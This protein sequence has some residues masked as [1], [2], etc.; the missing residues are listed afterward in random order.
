M[1]EVRNVAHVEEG[2]SRCGAG[3]LPALM[4]GRESRLAAWQAAPQPAC[5]FCNRGRMFGAVAVL[6]LVF[7]M[8]C[9]VARAADTTAQ[10]PPLPKKNGAVL[11][12]AQKS[13]YYGERSVKVYLFYPGGT[14]EGVKE[15]TGLFLSL[16]NWGGREHSGAPSPAALCSRYNTIAI[17]V[18]YLQSGM[19]GPPKDGHPYDFGYL[20]ALDALRGLF[21]VYD[22]L[23]RSGVRFSKGRIY[24]TGGS[25]GGNVTLMAN[26]L[27]PRT[28]ACIVDFSGM[29][30]LTDDIAYNLP[31]GSRLNAGY[32]KAPTHPNSLTKDAQEI[33]D[34]GHA[35]H[36]ATAEELGSQCKVI[37]SHG[38][39]DTACLASDKQRVVNGMRGAGFDVEAHFITDEDVDGKLIKNC[40]HSVGSRTSLLMH[41]ADKYLSP[42]SDAMRV[43]QCVPDFECR[44][45][46]VAYRT[47][48][49]Q[50]VIS[51]KQGYPV[52]AFLPV[53]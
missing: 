34:P 33:R 8:C 30:S 49:G 1:Y 11:I 4:G 41:F 28:F 16:H 50:Y 22:G 38:V 9:P 6:E 27:A 25:G 29:A 23:G 53:K 5:A 12:A 52:G 10:W 18:D 31:G 14:I 3:S 21:Y 2:R 37:V 36:L 39:K 51:Y 17:C 47:A 46:K 7:S 13:P 48:K 45:E 32:S 19:G 26:K 40:G 44:D 42:K 43:R 35:A 20:Q 24:C 15:S